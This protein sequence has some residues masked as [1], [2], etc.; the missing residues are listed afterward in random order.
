MYIS[1]LNGEKK[2]PVRKAEMYFSILEKKTLVNKH[3]T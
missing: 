1:K 2:S 3:S